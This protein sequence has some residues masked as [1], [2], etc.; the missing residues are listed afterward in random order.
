[1]SLVVG[2]NTYS[3]LAP[4][5]EY[6]DAMG[7]EATATTGAVLRAMNY[8]ETQT[9]KGIPTTADQDLRWPRRNVFYD[10]YYIPDDEI[11]GNL[12]KALYEATYI[13]TKVPGKLSPLFH[14]REIRREKIDVLEIQYEP[15]Y[16]DK[17]I[18]DNEPE[19]PA[20]E[21]LLSGLIV[22]RGIAR[23]IKMELA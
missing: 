2:T 5:Q 7:Y 10:G 23:I 12:I 4:V 11:P 22:P 21:N 6:F 9:Y 1:M 20:L 17:I 19:F 3:L 14:E 15:T 13:E 16:H 18:K 8:I